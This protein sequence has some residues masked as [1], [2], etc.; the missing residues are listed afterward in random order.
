MSTIWFILTIIIIILGFLFNKSKFYNYIQFIWIG[1]LMAG[2]AGGM[3]FNVHE[4]IFNEAGESGVIFLSSSW[5]YKL[6]CNV[7]F[8]LGYTFTNMNTIISILSLIVIYKLINNNT[9]KRCLVTSLFMIFPFADCIIQKRNFCAMIFAIIGLWF[10]LKNQ[11][12]N[13][14]KSL[15]LIIIAAQIHPTFYVYLLVWF[16]FKFDLKKIKKYIPILIVISFIMIPIIPK[17]AS[18]IFPG[19]KITFYFETAK[20]P[21]YQSIC[22]WILHYVYFIL[23]NIIFKLT[24]CEDKTILNGLTKLNYIMLIFLCLYYYEPTFFRIYRNLLLIF[25]IGI[26]IC[27][28]LEKGL[29]KKKLGYTI[30]LVLFSVLVFTSQ[31]VIFG[32]FGFDRLIVPI[33]TENLILK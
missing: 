17:L 3:D 15:I 8:I 6:F 33:F 27:Y 16:L 5:L 4:F 30:L 10:L 29:P 26:G 7:F 23:F 21:L 25:F 20:I 28:D 22:W 12:E 13:K 19:S 1:I 9:E 18:F 24:E 32:D 11:N 31:F 14:L 2:N